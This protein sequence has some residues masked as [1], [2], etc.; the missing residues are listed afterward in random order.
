[1]GGSKKTPKRPPNR[2]KSLKLAS[3]SRVGSRGAPL[4]LRTSPWGSAGL[5]CRDPALPRSPPAPQ[6]GVWGGFRGAVPRNVPSPLRWG[7]LGQR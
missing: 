6:K 2:P 5:Q 1:M 3:G 7:G 4:S